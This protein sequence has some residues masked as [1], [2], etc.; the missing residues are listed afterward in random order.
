MSAKRTDPVAAALERGEQPTYGAL[1]ARCADLEMAVSAA[2]VLL[3][4]ISPRALTRPD[5]DGR[6]VLVSIEDLRY[7]EE[8]TDA[9]RG[10]GYVAER[11]AKHGR[12]ARGGAR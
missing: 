4:R 2:V 10:A 6:H 5:T 1:L 8:Q 11:R 9:V 3:A 7:L 12:G